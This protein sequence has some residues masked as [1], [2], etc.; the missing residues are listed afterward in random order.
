M[1]DYRTVGGEGSVHELV[2]I[3][4]EKVW[5]CVS[6]SAYDE[7]LEQGIQALMTCTPSPA[8]TPKPTPKVAERRVTLQKTAK[9]AGKTRTVKHVELRETV[10][11]EVFE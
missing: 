5:L 3:D 10:T 9:W 1:A 4:G 2:E 8:P 7:H 11:T 6:S